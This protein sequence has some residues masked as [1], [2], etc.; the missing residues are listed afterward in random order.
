MIFWRGLKKRIDLS[1]VVV[2]GFV[3]WSYWGIIGNAKII[4][5]MNDRVGGRGAVCCGHWG[6]WHVDAFVTGRMLARV[7][8]RR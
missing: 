7:A 6:E 4:S 8:G 5:L 2:K 3:V 1:Q